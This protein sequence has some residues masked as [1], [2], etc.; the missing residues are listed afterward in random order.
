MAELRGL[1]CTRYDAADGIDQP[2][3]TIPGFTP[4][5]QEARYLEQRHEEVKRLSASE[6]RAAIASLMRSLPA[7]RKVQ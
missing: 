6:D 7:V 3:C 4:A 2:Y 5:E 1:L